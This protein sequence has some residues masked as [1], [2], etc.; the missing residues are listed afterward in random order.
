LSE[1]T[2]LHLHAK[3]F[4]AIFADWE[5]TYNYKYKAFPSVQF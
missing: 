5:I 3:H 4:L 2:P 1:P